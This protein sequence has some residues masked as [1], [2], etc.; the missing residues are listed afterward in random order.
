MTILMFTPSGV[1]FNCLNGRH[2]ICGYLGCKC[3]ARDHKQWWFR[4]D[5]IDNEEE[6][7]KRERDREAVPDGSRQ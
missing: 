6:A 1:C 2:D 4:D 7:L 3:S 5:G